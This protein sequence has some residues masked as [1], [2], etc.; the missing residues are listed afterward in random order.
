[1]VKKWL[2]E[3]LSS[4]PTVIAVLVGNHSVDKVRK[5]IGDTIPLFASPGTIRGDYSSDSPDLAN[6]EQRAVTNLI[7]ASETPE[8]AEKEIALWFGND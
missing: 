6:L 2:I 4:G 1:M 5:L 3:Y 8:E 7:H